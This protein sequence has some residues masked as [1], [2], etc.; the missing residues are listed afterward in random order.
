MSLLSKKIALS[1]T[2]AGSSLSREE[3]ESF[4][5]EPMAAAL[6][7]WSGRSSWSLT[8]KDVELGLAIDAFDE[9]NETDACLIDS[10]NQL[11]LMHLTVAEGLEKLSTANAL[12][13]MPDDISEA[14]DGFSK[15]HNRVLAET[16]IESVMN[17]DLE[18]GAMTQW[19]S[20]KDTKLHCVKNPDTWLCKSVWVVYDAEEEKEYS[21]TVK[22]DR[23]MLP[24]VT[25]DEAEG[26]TPPDLDV[27]EEKLGPC[28]LP[29]R[30]V[31]GKVTLSIADCMKLEIGQVFGLPEIDFNAVD[32][33]MPASDDVLVQATL[34]THF[35]AKAVRLSSAVGDDFLVR[36]GSEIQPA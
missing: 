36:Y 29:V 30:I 4:L 11:W 22:L 12:G 25:S 3:M 17:L 18:E 24:D 19:I 10:G 5:G 15:L 33:K 6:S 13:M 32:M 1:V 8:C 28:R 2:P 14:L 23:R 35:G 27:L 20:S 31:G 34:G 9:G 26:N 7:R 16:L 21:M